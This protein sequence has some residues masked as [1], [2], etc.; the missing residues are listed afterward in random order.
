MHHYHPTSLQHL[1]CD[2]HKL[3]VGNIDINWIWH[4]DCLYLSNTYELPKLHVTQ[5]HEHCELDANC[6]SHYHRN[7]NCNWHWHWLW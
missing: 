7:L 3:R 1:N 6:D 4:P 5:Q 2:S